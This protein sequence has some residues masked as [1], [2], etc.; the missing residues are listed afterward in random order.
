MKENLMSIS[1]AGLMGAA[2]ELGFLNKV[3]RLMDALY[4]K[5]EKQNLKKSSRME[6]SLVQI[7]GVAID[8]CQTS[9][10][11]GKGDLTDFMIDCSTAMKKVL[12]FVSG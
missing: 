1:R 4:W 8:W 5:N 12:G 11:S 7:T 6:M 10:S 2:W 9:L 3:E